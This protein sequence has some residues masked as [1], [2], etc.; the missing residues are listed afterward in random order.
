[1]KHQELGQYVIERSKCKVVL[2]TLFNSHNTSPWAKTATALNC[3]ISPGSSGSP[4]LNKRGDV[5]GIV[6]AVFSGWGLANFK[7]V[8]KLYGLSFETFLGEIHPASYFTNLSCI[9]DP[10]TKFVNTELCNSSEDL[11]AFQCSHMWTEFSES[12]S[13]QFYKTWKKNLP[14]IFKYEYIIDVKNPL[15]QQALPVCVKTQDQFKNS[16][17][18]IQNS[19]NPSS[20][21]V[22]NLIFE[23]HLITNPQIRVNKSQR[24]T[25]IFLEESPTTP[26][27]QVILTE[28]NGLWSGEIQQWGDSDPDHSMIDKKTIEI[29][30]CT[31]DLNSSHEILKFNGEPITLE[32]YQEIIVKSL[33]PWTN[34]P[35]KSCL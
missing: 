35:K 30:Y 5:I 34:Y 12:Q 6:Q 33:Q 32:K 25:P 2:N 22:I 7:N 21:K 13:R 16:D 10:Q 4:V 29:P 18:F 19:N 27:S 24:L 11:N 28:N 14:S 3:N 8:F 9:L 31:D 20:K 17:Q 1:M 23:N 26:N 15:N